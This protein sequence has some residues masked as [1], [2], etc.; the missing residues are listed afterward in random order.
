M[1]SRIVGSPSKIVL[2]A[3]RTRRTR[4]PN[5]RI[6]TSNIGEISPAVILANTA[7]NPQHRVV[8]NNRQYAWID[9]L[10]PYFSSFSKNIPYREQ[11]LE[12]RWQ[13]ALGLIL[14]RLSILPGKHTVE[15]LEN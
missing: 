1:C 12:V 7:F 11:R 8:K 10:T 4:V 2:L 5:Q 14:E 13:N 3:K 9:S 15:F 6:E